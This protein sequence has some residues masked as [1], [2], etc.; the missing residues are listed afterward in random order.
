MGRFLKVYPDVYPS[1]PYASTR[2]LASLAFVAEGFRA[3][4]N[5]MPE[6]TYVEHH[7]MVNLNEHQELMQVRAGKDHWHLLHPG[8]VVITPAFMPNAWRWNEIS[9]VIAVTICPGELSSFLHGAKG[10]GALPMEGP[11]VVTD[12]VFASLARGLLDAA[13][14]GILQ[15]PLYLQTFESAILE[16]IA[17][18]G[19]VRDAGSSS[20]RL[21]KRALR[22]AIDFIHAHREGGVRVGAVAAEAGMSQYH[23]SRLFRNAT[24]VSPHR[25]ILDLRLAHSLALLGGKGG[26]TVAAIAAETGFSDQSHFTNAFRRRYGISPARCRRH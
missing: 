11:A 15:T 17:V 13:E 10:G 12:P 16:R 3:P 4:P 25:F 20:A 24:G 7:L 1:G 6:Q 18:I 8:D 23:F 9:N 21:S 5:E 19:G 14:K 2:A 26:K 22:K